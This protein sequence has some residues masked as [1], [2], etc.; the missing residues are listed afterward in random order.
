[1]FSIGAFKARGVDGLHAHFYHSHW[2]L[3]G[4][5]CLALV[6]LVSLA[7]PFLMRLTPPLSAWSQDSIRQYMPINLCNTNYKIIS[8]II[9]NKMR[10]HVESMISPNQK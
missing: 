5:T 9:V 4:L 7:S 6:K 10:P 3:Y 1:M 2:V 8:K